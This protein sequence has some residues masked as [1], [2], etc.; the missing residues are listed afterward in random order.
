MATNPTLQIGMPLEEFLEAQEIQPF[1]LIDGAR[2]DRMP[3]VFGHSWYIRWLFLVLYKF[4]A[5]NKLGEVFQETTYAQ[6]EGK[7]WVTGA[8]IPDLM[9]YS[10][11]HI[12]AFKQEYDDW[13]KIP[14]FIAPVLT[15][16][17]ISPTERYSDIIK[18]VNA[19]LANG[20]KLI[21]AID[22]ESQTVT[23]YHAEQITILNIEDTLD[24]KDILPS[25]ELALRDLFAA[26]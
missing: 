2:I 24:G 18:K 13:R 22:V 23:V 16:E 19:D 7:K 5:E 12:E 1:E 26:E 15:I 4:T 17:V 20:V 3:N 10:A 6:H 21:W 11:G 25:F 8:R 9:F 14:L